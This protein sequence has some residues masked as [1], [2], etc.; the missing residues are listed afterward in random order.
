MVNIIRESSGQR[1]QPTTGTFSTTHIRIP[2][3]Y[4]SGITLVMPSDAA[5]AD[6]LLHAEELPLL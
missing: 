4:Q 5:A 1:P 6:E 2:A 3:S